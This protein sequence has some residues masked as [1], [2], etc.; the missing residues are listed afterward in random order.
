MIC[1]IEMA[2]FCHKGRVRSNNEDNYLCAGTFLPEQH[3]GSEEIGLRTLQVK[4]SP[5]IAVFDGMGGE[6][7]GETA[8]FLGART[9]D[10][11]ARRSVRQ[12]RRAPDRFLNN[13]CLSMNHEVCD[14][15]ARNKIATMGSTLVAA[16]F[17]KKEF[18]VCNL[19]DSRIYLL[20]DGVLT[21][22]S[23]DHVAARRAFG[24]APLTQ[25]LG[26]PEEDATPEPS[27]VRLPYQDGMRLLLCTDGLTDM[28]SP[29][30]IRR[31]L[32]GEVRQT[33]ALGTIDQILAWDPLPDQQEACSSPDLSTAATLLLR[34]ALT[35][36][37]RDN[38]TGILCD[39]H[40]GSEEEKNKTG[41]LQ[42]LTRL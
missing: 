12:I 37:G 5:V 6:S 22:L 23:T 26:L 25:Y 11:C 33:Q 36:G 27:M 31:I 3:E 4:K 29:D 2:F 24:K 38:V 35:A 20:Q 14:Y 39:I 17:G 8:S 15:A 30:R 9:L 41:L 1:E 18:A 16:A 19:G 21:Q 28:L 40:A 32:T 42:W 34:D 7:C 13:A 10:T